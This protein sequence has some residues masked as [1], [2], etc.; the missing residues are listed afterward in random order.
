MLIKQNV[1]GIKLLEKSHIIVWISSFAYLLPTKYVSIDQVEYCIF[2]FKRCF[3]G[4][5]FLA[6]K[7]RRIHDVLSTRARPQLSLFAKRCFNKSDYF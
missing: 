7:Y 1:R 5:L 2:N 4:L 6:L 3:E